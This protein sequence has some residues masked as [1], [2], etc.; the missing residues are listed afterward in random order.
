MQLVDCDV[1]LSGDQ[2]HVVRKRDITVAEVHLLQVIHGADAVSNVKPKGETRRPHAEELDRLR[3]IYRRPIQKINP[4]GGRS[5]VD[6]V[7]S[8]PSPKL[9]IKLADIGFNHSTVAK[10]RGE[11]RKTKKTE[12]EA[13]SDEQ[14]VIS[15][16]GSGPADDDVQATSA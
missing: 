2:L 5:I 6:S 12:P 11:R 7:Y 1:R 3:R 16:D 8:G 13:E 14:V 10:T 4:D 15:E 9:P